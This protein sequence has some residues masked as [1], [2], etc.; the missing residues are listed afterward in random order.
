MF[1]LKKLHF[2]TGELKSETNSG[3]E[4]KLIKFLVS[5]LS[6]TIITDVTRVVTMLL[7]YSNHISVMKGYSH[8]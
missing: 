3:K 6:K 5:V 7:L 2:C 8:N 1:F 4:H